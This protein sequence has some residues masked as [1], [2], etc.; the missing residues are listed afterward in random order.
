M[1]KFL[2]R[3]RPHQYTGH[4]RAIATATGRPAGPATDPAATAGATRSATATG[5]DSATKRCATGKGQQEVVNNAYAG[6]TA[7]NNAS[8]I[9][10]NAVGNIIAGILEKNEEEKEQRAQEYANEQAKVAANSENFVAQIKAMRADADYQQFLSDYAAANNGAGFTTDPDP[11]TDASLDDDVRTQI[12]SALIHESSSF[13]DW[14]VAPI[15]TDDCLSYG[16]NLSMDEVISQINNILTVQ[17]ANADSSIDPDV[18][19][20]RSHQINT[21]DAVGICITAA[22]DIPAS[23]GISNGGKYAS[24]G[25]Y[26]ATDSIAW[27]NIDLTKVKITPRQIITQGQPVYYNCSYTFY[28]AAKGPTAYSTILRES[29][30]D[31]FDTP[32]E[33]LFSGEP[34][35]SKRERK[36]YGISF[37]LR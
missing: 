30:G 27:Q 29:N 28:I 37:G 18:D 12:H 9:V 16:N 10:N 34:Q 17:Y 2:Q 36:S 31:D 6:V 3:F 8:Q 35:L 26:A 22:G 21:I 20:T 14:K 23:S 7:N 15:S 5:P 4:Q 33:C 11:L 25:K 24:T 1:G 32:P 19:G 13:N